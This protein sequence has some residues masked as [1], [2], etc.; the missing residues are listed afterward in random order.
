[1]F[2]S[3]TCRQILK[4]PDGTEAV[5]NITTG[6]ATLFITAENFGDDVDVGIVSDSLTLTSRPL[7]PVMTHL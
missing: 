3:S 1:M 5:F 6:Y 4:S 2:S 7:L